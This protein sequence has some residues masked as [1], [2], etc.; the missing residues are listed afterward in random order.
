M[1]GWGLW[2]LLRPP[3]RLLA[4]WHFAVHNSI[5]L[6]MA[7]ALLPRI[8][9]FA[10]FGGLA[11]TTASSEPHTTG[12]ARALFTGSRRTVTGG[13]NLSLRRELLSSTMPVLC[14]SPA[15]QLGRRTSPENH[16]IGHQRLLTD[17]AAIELMRARH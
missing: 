3:P 16:H 2:D 10:G 12:S 4:R 7:F 15:H 11:E 9:L 13:V 14:T 6:D 8:P 1:Y 5:S 17:G